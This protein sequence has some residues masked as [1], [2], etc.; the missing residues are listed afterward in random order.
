MDRLVI[1]IEHQTIQVSKEMVVNNYF[2]SSIV[3]PEV[4]NLHCERARV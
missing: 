4:I 3:F 2:P 1:H